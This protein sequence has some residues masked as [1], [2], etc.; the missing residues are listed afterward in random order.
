MLSVAWISSHHLAFA[1]LPHTPY[2]GA[3]SRMRHLSLA[4]VATCRITW[5]RVP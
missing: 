3:P 1:F 2:I 5:G 4:S